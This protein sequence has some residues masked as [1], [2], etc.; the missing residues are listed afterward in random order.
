MATAFS[1]QRADAWRTAALSDERIRYALGYVAVQLHASA[2]H[3]NGLVEEE[4]LLEWLEEALEEYDGAYVPRQREQAQAI[5][6]AAR[7][8]GGFLLERG[9]TIY[10]FVHRTFQEYFA[11]HYLA[12]DRKASTERILA[13]LDDPAWQEVL[14][15]AV[16]EAVRLHPR[17]TTALLE[18]VQA[19]P[20]PLP[21][22]I[23]QRSLFLAR[24]LAELSSAYIPAHVVRQA[25]TQLVAAHVGHRARPSAESS[26]S[27]QSLRS[28][29]VAAVRRLR[30]APG[31]VEVMG[32][33]LAD[34]RPEVRLSATELILEAEWIDAELVAPLL[35]AVSKYAEPAATPREAL[36]RHHK[37]VPDAFTATLVPARE[38]LTDR[39]LVA[40]RWM[41]DLWRTILQL[42]YLRPDRGADALPADVMADSALT[43]LLRAAWFE[44]WPDT[45]LLTSLTNL[46]DAHAPGAHDALLVLAVWN[47]EHVVEQA[48][49]ARR[50][51]GATPPPR[52]AW[53]VPHC[54][55]R[56][57]PRPYPR[58]SP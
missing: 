30:A 32:T 23:P 5:L 10:G 11:A 20:E 17:Q 55:P 12:A 39:A 14:V 4:T 35:G 44:D 45:C 58:P 19:A 24:A 49:Q 13:R 52:L 56:S 27:P 31:S 46:V 8:L 34:A 47:E 42:L 41:R 7:S 53:L 37:Q 40:Q 21:G 28:A 26:W 6:F 54:R 57:Y 2:I 22:L 15:L 3:P 1:R 29:I 36:L 16:A 43:P 9:G 48:P 51:D 25:V 50:G 18:A 38:L 33:C